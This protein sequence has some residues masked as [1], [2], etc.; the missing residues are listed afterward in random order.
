MSTAIVGAILLGVGMVGYLFRPV[1]FIRRGLFLASA[2]G[3]LIPI[4]HSGAFV[5]LTWIVNGFGFALAVLLVG[6]EWFA[7]EPSSRGLA[8]ERAKAPLR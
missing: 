5:A 7:R 4:T 1:G 3:L 8:A 2:I 6:G